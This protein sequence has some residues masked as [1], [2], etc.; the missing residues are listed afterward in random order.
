[1]IFLTVTLYS[2]PANK[3]LSGMNEAVFVVQ[4]IEPLTGVPEAMV[5]TI[6]LELTVN[7]FKVLLK[8][9][10][11]AVL[12]GMDEEPLDGEV[13]DTFMHPDIINAATI[14]RVM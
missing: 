7:G 13:D 8:V 3:A 11:I 1:M 10:L 6:D 2:V 12:T 5:T 4:A 9:I 14:R